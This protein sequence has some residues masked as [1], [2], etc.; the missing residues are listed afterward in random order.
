M[1]MAL[2]KNSCA[3][4]TVMEYM[5]VILHCTYK[6]YFVG[7]IILHKRYLF[8][9]RD[10]NDYVNSR[11]QNYGGRSQGKTKGYKKVNAFCLW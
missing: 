2:A 9:T 4:N 1:I 7:D 6:R 10:Y 11:K 3:F 5:H 8:Y